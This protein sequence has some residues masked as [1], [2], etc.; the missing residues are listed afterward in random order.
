MKAIIAGGRAF[1]GESEHYGWLLW[2]KEKLSIDE[3]VS[4]GAKG[5]DMFG[6]CFASD[7]NINVTVFR[8]N[9]KTH[10][11]SAGPLRNVEMAK[12]ADIC[13]LFPGGA[14]TQSMKKCAR[15]YGL[16][17]EEW[18]AEQGVQADKQ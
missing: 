18:D 6:E 16:H 12:Y 15:Q 4:G 10:G 3:I 7:N 17:I 14:G 1:K 9:W 2:L 13:I 5:A 8:A 11:K